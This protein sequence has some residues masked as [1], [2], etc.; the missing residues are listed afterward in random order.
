MSK[1]LEIFGQTFS[2]VKGFKA[3]DS[4]GGVSYYDGYPEY[5]WLRPEGWPDID[6]LVPWDDLDNFDGCYFTYDNTGQNYT[7]ASF[8]CTT[9]SGQYIVERGHI[10]NGV[11]V[12]DTTTSQNSNTDY[13]DNYKNCGYTYPIYYVHPATEGKHITACGH[14]N[15]SASDGLVI[16]PYGT[17]SPCIERAGHFAYITVVG[18]GGSNHQ[19]NTNN[20][21]RDHLVWGD[22]KVI[23][24][25]RY[26]WYG[27]KALEEIDFKYWDTSLWEIT[28]M[29]GTFN[30]CSSLRCLDFSQLDVS[31]WKVTNWSNTFSCVNLQVI[32]LTGF[33]E[34]ESTVDAELGGE[35]WYGGVGCLVICKISELDNSSPNGNISYY[36]NGSQLQELYPMVMYANQNYSN[37]FKLSYASLL[38]IL[39][40]LPTLPTGTTYTLTLGN[41]RAKLTAEEIA[42]ATNKGWT[43]A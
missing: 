10:S 8:W 15:I 17:T 11:F 29:I 31:N 3:K 7:I 40:T 6:S 35:L 22:K 2:N 20:L 37:C 19:L 13:K 39:N 24:S 42:I 18:G 43:V 4:N 30:G 21:V 41:I 23:T 34:T 14:V 27:C 38:R 26:Y 9:E 1:T 28:D 12:T 16:N 33:G 32:D 36:P 5:K 25:L